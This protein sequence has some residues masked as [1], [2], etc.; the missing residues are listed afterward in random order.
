MARRAE[1][2][3][4]QK[5]LLSAAVLLPLAA[6]AVWLGPPYW[7]VLVGVIAVVMAWEW[8]GMCAFGQPQS[9]YAL[10]GVEPAGVISMLAM[11]VAMAVAAGQAYRLS[12]LLLVLGGALACVIGMR[13]SGGRGGWHGFGT[14][15]VGLPSIAIIWLRA[16]A[17]G[18]LASMVWVLALAIAVDTGAYAA[19]RSIG[20]PKLAPR[21]S[22]NKTWA[23]LLGG[24]AA[25]M[26]VGAVAALWLGAAS[27][28]PLVLASALLGIV[29]QAGDLVESGFKRYFGVKDSG[30]LIPGHGGFLDRV[31]GLLAVALA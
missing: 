1:V 22:P 4:L 12:L 2:S 26:V 18:G 25:G 21:I 11:T 30:H 28:W 15:Y 8:A 31:D 3:A 6:A 16:Q 19:G 20:G 27:V 23:G 10:F 17:P 14:L 9:R 5:R 7:D 29:E 13:R 24:V